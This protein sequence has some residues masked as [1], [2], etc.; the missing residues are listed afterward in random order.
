MAAE[1]IK[2]T[3]DLV[4]ASSETQ[5]Y[6]LE[7]NQENDKVLEEPNTKEPS[8]QISTEKPLN[9]LVEIPCGVKMQV[10]LSDNGTVAADQLTPVL[11]KD[12][13]SEE[14][15][16][17]LSEISGTLAA[18]VLFH[19]SPEHIPDPTEQHQ[20]PC[21][22]LRFI[23][24]HKRDRPPRKP[25]DTLSSWNNQQFVNRTRIECTGRR[26]CCSVTL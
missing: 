22:K 7:V 18:S 25:P 24:D 14:P 4:T 20:T 13:K 6:H 21:D 2:D 17:K 12:Q 10:I 1:I 26:F 19:V 11:I 15:I 16:N 3:P 5:S 8:T 9:T 23:K